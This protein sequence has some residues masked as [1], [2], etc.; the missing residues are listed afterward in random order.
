[1]TGARK[2]AARAQDAKWS[3][4]R[5][6]LSRV[7]QAAFPW[8]RLALALVLFLVLLAPTPG[9][10]PVAQWIVASLRALTGAPGQPATAAPYGGLPTN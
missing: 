4:S 9:D 3:R 10:R 2:S 8:Q 6:V 1:M 7:A 5:V